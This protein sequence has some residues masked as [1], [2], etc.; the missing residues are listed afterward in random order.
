MCNT[1]SSAVGKTFRPIGI[2]NLI[3]LGI[4]LRAFLDIFIGRRYTTLLVASSVLLTG[5]ESRDL[6][7][8]RGF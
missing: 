1:L 2:N 8:A 7:G 6:F 3:S 5:M 4:S